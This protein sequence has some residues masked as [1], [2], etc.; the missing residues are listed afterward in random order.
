MP[1]AT[2]VPCVRSL[3]SGWQFARAD[4]KNGKAQYLV[5]HDRAGDNALTAILTRRCD[6]H[7]APQ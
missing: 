5:N 6:T 1:S 7:G 2:L 3:P 4:V